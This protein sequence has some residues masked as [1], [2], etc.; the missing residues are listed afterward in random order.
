M[1]TAVSEVGPGIRALVVNYS[2]KIG[3]QEIE[4][5]GERIGSMSEHFYRES[6]GKEFE[7]LRMGSRRD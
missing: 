7:K 3:W 4:G 5:A 2:R 6:E 1:K